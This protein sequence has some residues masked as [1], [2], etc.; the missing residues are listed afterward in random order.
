MKSEN[1][2]LMPLEITPEE[3]AVM[4]KALGAFP[5]SRQDPLYQ[6][7]NSILDKIRLGARRQLEEEQKERL[8]DSAGGKDSAI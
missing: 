3:A 2:K 7:G 8:A 4:L 1:V 5:Q 6:A